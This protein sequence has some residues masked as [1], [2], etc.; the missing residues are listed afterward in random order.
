MINEHAMKPH[1]KRGAQIQSKGRILLASAGSSDFASLACCLERS[2]YQVILKQECAC[3]KDEIHA[4][5]PD[6]LIL[7]YHEEQGSDFALLRSIKEMDSGDFLPVILA[8][9]NEDLLEKLRIFEEG[10]DDLVCNPS[11]QSE[12]LCKVDMLLHMRL[13][14]D[15]YN[16]SVTVGKTLQKHSSQGENTGVEATKVQ[17]YLIKWVDLLSENK[18]LLHFDRDNLNR[19]DGSPPILQENICTKDDIK[20]TKELMVFSVKAPA[21][22]KEKWNSI[23]TSI[24]EALSN[25][26][27][28]A[29]TGTISVRKTHD[30]LDIQI[31]DQGPGISYKNILRSIYIKRF[32]RQRIHGLGYP[33]M[34]ELADKMQLGTCPSG[35]SLLLQFTF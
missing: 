22:E 24:S 20:R 5:S 7:D 35:T 13:L 4:V 18:I 25:V 8:S 21:L 14:I 19:S 11:G 27:K 33:L 12:F 28:Y 15:I 31:D 9:C 16:H 26:I 30:T 10:A 3:V 17:E 1:P 2:H 29:R 6:L 34:M 32:S 23:I